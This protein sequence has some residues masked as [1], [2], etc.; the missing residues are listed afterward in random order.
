MVDFVDA[1]AAGLGE[2]GRWFHYGLTSSDVLDTALAL[3]VQAVYLVRRPRGNDAWWRAGAM[4][5]LMM[6]LLGTSVWEGH[7]GAATRVAARVL[8]EGLQRALCELPI[9]A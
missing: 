7:P 8:D 1:V 2:E 9:D 5:V 3:T 6:A 4:W